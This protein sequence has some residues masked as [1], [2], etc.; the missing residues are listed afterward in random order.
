MTKTALAA[1]LG[2][3]P[4]TALADTSVRLI[5]DRPLEVMA[6]GDDLNDALADGP[7]PAGEEFFL[8][9]PVSQDTEATAELVIWPRERADCPSDPPSGARQIQRLGMSVTTDAGVRVLR[10]RVAPLQVGLDYCFSLR[11]RVTLDGER[12]ETLSALVAEDLIAE[13]PLPGDRCYTLDDE[14]RFEA[15]LTD[16]LDRMRAPVADPEAVRG[17]AAEILVRYAAGEGPD[18]CGEL[19]RYATL[20][21]VRARIVSEQRA[22]A[23]EAHAN[24]SALPLPPAFASP[25]VWADERAIE[26][27]R[28]ITLSPSPATLS[29]VRGQLRTCTG[30]N[31]GACADWAASLDSV[32]AL[33]ES[34]QAAALSQLGR[35]PHR[36]PGTLNV[37][38]DGRLFGLDVVRDSLEVDPQGVIAQLGALSGQVRPQTADTL[39]RWVRTLEAVDELRDGLNRAAAD[40]DAADG[41][42]RGARVRMAEAV[43]DAVRAPAVRQRLVV[44]MGPINL[45]VHAGSERTR[46]AKNFATIEAGVAAAVP[47]VD[48]KNSAWLAP[49]VGMRLY[50]TPVD[51]DIPLRDLA[52]T[53]MDRL[54]QR[55]SVT[56]GFVPGDGPD[57]EGYVTQPAFGSVYPVI[58]GGWRFTHFS[59]VSAGAIGFRVED[60]NPASAAT[61]LMW[62]GFVGLSLDID[63]VYL[64]RKVEL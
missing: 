31:A 55:A 59:A 1:L 33:P 29:E 22:A 37:Y 16:A 9:V 63:L 25:L 53:P 26:I 23:A 34:Q 52:G 30:Q 17:A 49:Y 6:P 64:I 58:A 39:T 60:P 57:I 27:A 48:D 36:A 28:L 47:L 19:L 62:A 54:R 2:L 11:P 10:G 15:A 61:Q 45:G 46:D 12:L 21:R 18:A 32:L 56:V 42:A 20:A 13:V 41:A 50:S 5:L 35:D 38:A 7:F 44:A 24:L 40:L 4:A 43:R 8:D 14:A 3:M 51:R